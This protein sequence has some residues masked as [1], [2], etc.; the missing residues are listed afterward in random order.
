MRRYIILM[1]GFISLSL[2]GHSF[3][4]NS[5]N[6]DKEVKNGEK[7]SKIFILKNNTND[8][9]KYRL[10]SDNKNV[11]ITPKIILLY[12]KKQKN[13]KITIN[14]T[15]KMGENRYYLKIFEETLKKPISKGIKIN[16]TINIEQRYYLK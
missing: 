3:W 6:F 5:S 16:K 10:T 4:L 11:D 14:G 8:K 7:V 9:K 13:F 2:K 1:I 12:P 15:G